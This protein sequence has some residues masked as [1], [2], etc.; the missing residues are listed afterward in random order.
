[1]FSKKFWSH[2]DKKRFYNVNRRIM[3]LDS[4]T[5]SPMGSGFLLTCLAFS[6]LARSSLSWTGTG[7][8]SIIAER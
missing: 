6:F 8:V 1:M 5:I 7:I 3:F 2:K 4:M